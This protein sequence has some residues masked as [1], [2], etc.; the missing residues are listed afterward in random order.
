[1]GSGLVGICYVAAGAPGVPDHDSMGR[2]GTTTNAPGAATLPPPAPPSSAPMRRLLSILCA[3]CAVG[4][5]V[6][7]WSRLTA[8]SALVAPVPVGVSGPPGGAV[9]DTRGEASTRLRAARRACSVEALDPV[10]TQ[11]VATTAAAPANR[12]AWH[13]LAEA[14]LERAQQRTHLRGMSVGQ[15]VFTELPGEL[16]RD[17]E[18]GLA[19][20]AKARELGDESG[21]LFRIEAGLLSQQ[22]TGVATALQWNGAIAAALQQ[23]ADRTADDPQLHVALGLRKLLAPRWFGHDPEGALEHFEYAAKAGGDERPAV[24]A[25]MASYL[26]KRREQAIRWL[27]RAVADNPANTFAR[28]VLRRLVRGEPD[29]FGRDVTTAEIAAAK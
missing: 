27:E 10:V 1:M 8:G 4:I 9:P 11:L 2:S 28:V 15:P 5:G 13:L 19:A 23:A 7:A 12:D 14:C 16:A 20:V 21:D 22:I 24:F 3:L 29:P 6:T 17:V 18:Q 26:Q 25:A